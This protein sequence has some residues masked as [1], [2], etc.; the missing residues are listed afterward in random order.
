MSFGLYGVH[1]FD[2]KGSLYDGATSNDNNKLANRQYV[3]DA[4]AAGGGEWFSSVLAQQDAPPSTPSTG[5]RYLVGSSGSGAWASLSNAIVEWDG[6]AWDSTSPDVGAPTAG[7]H[8]YIEGGS[9]NAGNTMIYRT[10]PST[11]WVVAA[12]ASGALLKTQNLSDLD[13][14]TTART[15]LGLG[16]LAVEDSINLG[17]SFATGTLPV[18]KGGTGSTSSPMIGLVT[19][20]DAA[21]A[22]TVIGTGTIATQDSDNV[23]ITGGSISGI[24]DIAISDGGT[25]ASDASTARSNLGLALGSDVQAHSDLLDDIS[26][27]T[28][29]DGTFLVGDANGDITAE[30]G[31]TAR[32]SLGLGTAA[33]L[34]TGVSDGDVIKLDGDLTSNQVVGRKFFSSIVFT[35]NN[36]FNYIY[37]GGTFSSSGSYGDVEGTIV[38][39]D[40]STNSWLV[41][42]TSGYLS[43]LNSGDTVSS[44]GYNFTYSSQ[45]TGR[46][47]NLGLG[48]SDL[49][50]IIGDAGSATSSATK[51]VAGFN[52][53]DFTAVQGFVS[54]KSGLDSGEAAKF[55]ADVSTA[56]LVKTISYTAASGSLI[57]SNAIDTSA[58]TVKT[59]VDVSAIQAGQIFESS[60]YS[61]TIQSTPTE[62]AG[63]YTITVADPSSNLQYLYDGGSFSIAGGDG[64][65]SAGAYG[66]A[67]NQT[68]AT[69][70]GSSAQGKV[71]KVA[72][73]AS[74]AENSLLAVNA[75]GEII[76][77]SA[78]EQGTV[79]S[80]ALADDDGDDTTAVTT[81]G[82]IVVKGGGS[83][84]AISS[85]VNGS[86]ELEILVE[87]ASTGQAGVA[88]RVSSSVH[89]GDNVFTG[90]D[91]AV[92]VSALG[93]GLMPLINGDGEII[94][95]TTSVGFY[96][97]N[98]SSGSFTTLDGHD[99]EGPLVKSSSGILDGSSALPSSIGSLEGAYV[100]D[101]SSASSDVSLNLPLSNSAG[102][103]GSTVTFKV[104]GLASGRKLTING[105]EYS[106]GHFMTIDG[107]NSV[108]LDQA[109]QSITVH[110]SAVMDSNT[111]SASKLCW[112]IL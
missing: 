78:G 19:A 68:I 69:G 9:N 60:G 39:I 75:S 55:V 23:T 13:N 83:N 27:L 65:V 31:A 11:G 32:T 85:N 87:D 90:F 91:S 15:N 49:K 89:T 43:N 80:I 28:I 59:S 37:T 99:L 40:S 104:Q 36:N 18:S 54:L 96:K 14:V 57:S 4:V 1:D 112:S 64:L 71:L 44:S 48:G 22:R 12:S 103:I 3:L 84:G 105:G 73:S 58:N 94:F 7:A 30:S 101:L 74:L 47:D 111:P 82:A 26:G 35:N 46:T 20:A 17:G 25:G 107:A 21:A 42:V 63:V 108:D 97:N 8:V 41:S 72:S 100:Y 56:H 62:S 50:S 98:G 79:T 88:K 34:D 6:A 77:G 92:S 2:I 95:D 29:A 86:G 81:S 52:S 61:F 10:S 33:I 109:R 24:A 45:G 53:D 66:D 16:D 38:E 51:G 70:V 76:A 106:G 110:L 5:D 67:A 102:D 93:A